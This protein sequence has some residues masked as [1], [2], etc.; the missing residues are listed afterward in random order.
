MS[1]LCVGVIDRLPSWSQNYHGSSSSTSNT[2][3]G[4]GTST[5]TSTSTS[6]LVL[7]RTLV[8]LLVPKLIYSQSDAD[9][10][11]NLYMLH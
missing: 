5:S 11:A 3:T 4:T 7:V 1:L 10:R 9:E 2:G 8:T 6:T